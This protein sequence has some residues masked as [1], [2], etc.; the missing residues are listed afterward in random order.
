MGVCMGAGMGVPGGPE[1]ACQLPLTPL[2]TSLVAAHPQELQDTAGRES[3]RTQ[4]ERDLPPLS[5]EAASLGRAAPG[6]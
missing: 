3:C 1:W 2:G 4:K 6:Q 5:R